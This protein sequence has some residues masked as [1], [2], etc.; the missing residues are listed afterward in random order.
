MTRARGT[1]GLAGVLLA[2]TLS[3]CG[4]PPPSALASV[5]GTAI[6]SSAL[7]TAVH[8]T[9]VLQ[10][11][12]LSTSPRAQRRYLV[13]L[14][15]DQLVL[16]WARSHH[17]GQDTGPAV[18]KFVS[19]FERYAG[20]QAGLDQALSAH[21][22]SRRAFRA[23]LARQYTLT[24]VFSQKTG[25]VA[26]PSQMAVARY[27]QTHPKLFTAPAKVLARDILVPSQAEARAVLSQVQHGASFAALARRD[28][29]D[30]ATRGVGGSLGWVAEGSASGLPLGV[31]TE[32]GR[33]TAGHYGIA[34]TRDGYYILEVQGVKPGTLT[35]LLA[36]S[37]AIRNQLWVEAKDHTFQHFVDGLRA[38]AKVVTYLR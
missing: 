21:H 10:N 1:G 29:K 36:V 5:N 13:H 18:T 22:L 35:P 15:N 19:Q 28:S 2:A 32:L 6:T 12:Q 25:S 34:P 30:P 16:N 17:V 31:Y 24:A 8:A 26:A 7:M 38:R 33:L 4:G 14:I 9:D 20:G 27:Y 3:A 37:A 11:T 23:F